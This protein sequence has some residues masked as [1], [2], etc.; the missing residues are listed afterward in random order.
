MWLQALSSNTGKSISLL[1]QFAA[2]LTICNPVFAQ[3]DIVSAFA[4]VYSERPDEVGKAGVGVRIFS[5]REYVFAQ[6]PPFLSKAHYLIGSMSNGNR[7]VPVT[8]GKVYV[9]T[10]LAGHEGSQEKRLAAE[11]FVRVEYPSFRLFKEQAGEI[12][13]FEK[14]VSFRRF[15]LGDIRY[16]GWAVPFFT[17]DVPPSVTQPAQIIWSPGNQYAKDTRLWQGCPSIERTGKRLWAA[18]FSGGTREPDTK[19]Y[20]IISYK[21][22]ANGWVD[23]AMVITHPDSNVRVMD[24]Q[25]WTDPEGSLWVFWVQNTGAKGFDGVW[26]TWAVRIKNPET[27]VPACTTPRRLCN[28]LM[29]NKPIALSTGEWLLPSYDW[30]NHQSAVYIS[31]DKGE[32]W[33]LQ[34]GPINPP[35]S[36]FYEHMCV[37]LKNGNIWMLQ[38]NIQ[39]SVSANKGKDW[40]PLDTI[41]EL[42]SANS[43]LYIGRLRSGNLLLVYNNDRK[44]RKNITAFLSE[45]E[46]KTWP[47]QLLIDE[48]DDVSYPDVAE[49][50]DGLI[51]VCY[52][53]GRRTDKEILMATF[54]ERDIRKG[55]FASRLSAQK[56]VISKAETRQVEKNP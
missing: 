35:V 21:D 37:E 36:N 42:T 41:P 13:I 26:G 20:G 4:H 5:D 33:T 31:R 56:Q 32:S 50:A 38:R 17:A 28:G 24:T 46:G 9:I 43:R 55:K 10:P 23:P 40:T 53:R 34:G 19:N 16:A 30:V 44:S 7:I 45:D 1:L 18:W 15:R 12:G 8:E 47:H 52:D 25:L 39:G 48:R 6:L 14:T 27:Q 2:A 49:T 3:P 11:G 22:E 51:Y 29:R 54:T